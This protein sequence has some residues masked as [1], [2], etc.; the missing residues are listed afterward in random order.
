LVRKIKRFNNEEKAV[1][2]RKKVITTRE[3]R[4]RNKEE[5]LVKGKKKGRIIL[6]L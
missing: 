5:R 6:R 1:R 4:R 3:K 2:G